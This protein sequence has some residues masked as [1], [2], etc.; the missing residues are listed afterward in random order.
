MVETENIFTFISSNSNIQYLYQDPFIAMGI[1]KIIDD[2]TKSLI[3]S[4][5]TCSTHISNLK[6]V[7]NIKDSVGKLITLKL[8]N[9]TNDMVGLSEIY[10]KSL[11]TGFCLRSY[12]RTF[13]MIENFNVDTKIQEELSRSKFRYLL[14][15]I[16]DKSKDRLNKQ[17]EILKFCGLIDQSNNITN[18]GFEFL[19]KSRKNQLWFIVLNSI[20]YY[21]SSE[22]EEQEMIL[23]IME[24]AIKR[25]I[26]VYF[27]TKWSDWYSFLDSIGILN[28]ITTSDYSEDQKLKKQKTISGN[29]VFLFNLDLFDFDHHKVDSKG[30]YLI[31]ET[32]FKIYAYNTTN[33]E[34]SLL[35]LF[36][37]TIF[38]LPNLTKAYFDEESVC[39]AFSKGITAKQ[40]ISYLNDFSE[41]IPVNVSNQI[42]IWEANQN[43]IKQY[44]AILYNDFLHLSDYVKLLKFIESKNALI[45]S[46]ETRRVIVAEER[47]HDE[48]K[49]YLKYLETQ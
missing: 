23:D 31:L 30:K 12:D 11:L 17:T 40:I 10:R 38:D 6:T 7:K 48:V 45:M 37:K 20:K 19:L 13:K 35:E 1:L 28:I 26:K 16:V 8:I 2:D 36:S 43:R 42:M 24:I 9:K 5:S 46:D 3:F 15:S 18:R 47:V 27:T 49:D 34:K 14:H 29:F 25:N 33:Y 39:K 32:N 41:N 4:L 22:K 21:S 44:D